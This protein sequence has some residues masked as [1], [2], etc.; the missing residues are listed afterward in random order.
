MK[1]KPWIFFAISFLCITYL[2][3][4]VRSWLGWFLLLLWTSRV[5]CFKDGK[6]IMQIMCFCCCAFFIVQWHQLQHTTHLNG[7][8]ETFILSLE[9]NSLKIDGDYLSCIGKLE[10]AGTMQSREK[11]A[12]QY[13]IPTQK[14]Q[15][16]WLTS[17]PPTKIWVQG[18]LIQPGQ[19]T[20]FNQFNYRDYLKRQN[21][22]WQLR[23]EKIK[24]T[25]T[26]AS[27]YQKIDGLRFR[28][29]RDID[30]QFHQK[31][32]SYLKILFF[33]EGTALAQPIKESY[34]ALGIIHL[35]SISGFHISYLTRVIRQFFL[36]LGMT[37]ERTNLLLVIILPFYGLLA[38]LSISIFRA[39]IQKVVQ[40]SGIILDKEISSLDAWALTL[41]LALVMNPYAIF[42]LSFQLSYSLSALFIMMGQQQWIRRLS[43]FQHNLLLSA[44][45]MVISVPI[46]G[47]HFYEVSWLTLFSNVLFIPLFTKALIPILVIL[48]FIRILVPHTFIFA[49]LNHI[50]GMVFSKFEWTLLKITKQY[51]FSFVL[52]RL[53]YFVLFILIGIIL[54]NLKKIE[55]KQRLSL[56]LQLAICTC[57]FWNRLSPLGYVVML[58]VGQ[59]DAILIKE[60]MTRK[61]TL[62]DTGG[63]VQWQEKEDWQQ[64]DREFTIGKNVVV[65]SIKSLGITQIDRLYITHPHADHMG[66]IKNIA[67]ELSIKEIAG[68]RHTL[69]DPAFQKQI[70]ELNQTK[71]LEIHNET[72][73]NYPT[74]NTFV[75]HPKLN[76]SDKNNQSL[77]LYVKIEGDTWLFTGDLEAEGEKD[78]IQSFPSLTVDYLKVGHHGSA[79]SSTEEFMDSVQPQIALISV[80]AKNSFGHPSPEIIQ[81]FT[82]QQIE[83]YTT[84]DNGAIKVNYYPALPIKINKWSK[85]IQTVN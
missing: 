82:E 78:F 3:L 49:G 60:P 12:V 18:E 83:L 65:P 17:V 33:G 55:Q 16:Q 76:Y 68:T 51:N 59:G 77:V 57:L 43:G 75:V 37:H 39:V 7:D 9:R 72:I 8:E 47:Y 11:L 10:A 38:G 21:I 31:I 58:D 36:R 22:H 42:E 25:H 62:I 35:F 4:G 44:L 48:L 45:A 56:P 13:Y 54:F 85:K 40:I 66:E 23:A 19:P 15:S 64:R 84:A 41:V 26:S 53:P 63:Q 46:L 61:I 27:F 74:N 14:E 24:T 79:T 71:L 5:M 32:A 67:R 69:I 28:I 6:I 1:N 52:G 50:V 80:G 30:A 2:M 70:Q 29:L 73:L 34:R 81:R 20:N